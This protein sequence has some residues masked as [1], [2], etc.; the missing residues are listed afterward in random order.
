MEKTLP[1][2]SADK[3]AGFRM[4]RSPLQAK[5]CNVVAVDSNE[6]LLVVVDSDLSIDAAAEL[7]EQLNE[8][9]GFKEA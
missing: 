3:V 7:V 1:K 9:Y 8:E 6:K 4:Y 5:Y 2:I